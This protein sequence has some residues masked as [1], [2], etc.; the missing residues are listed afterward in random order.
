MWIEPKVTIQMVSEFIERLPLKHKEKIWSR[1]CVHNYIPKDKYLNAL[2]SFLALCIK[3]KDRAATAPSKPEV[4]ARL[5]PFVDQMTLR[6]LQNKGMTLEQFNHHLH[7]WVLE[8]VAGLVMATEAQLEWQQEIEELREQVLVLEQEK[9]HMRRASEIELAQVLSQ[10]KH[11]D[12]D[13]EEEDYDDDEQQIHFL[14]KRVHECEESIF[15]L[16]STVSLLEDSV[17][18]CEIKHPHSHM[19]YRQQQLRDKTRDSEDD[20]DKDGELIAPQLISS[21]DEVKTVPEIE[22]KKHNLNE[23]DNGFGHSSREFEEERLA[24]YR[25]DNGVTKNEHYIGW[26]NKADKYL[27]QLEEAIRENTGSR[28]ALKEW[29]QQAQN[30]QITVERNK[31]ELNINRE[32]KKT[33]ESLQ[34]DIEHFKV[35]HIQQEKI[36]RQSVAKLHDSLFVKLLDAEADHEDIVAFYQREVEVLKQN[37]SNVEDNKM[38]NIVHSHNTIHSMRI[39]I[40]LLQQDIVSLRAQL[41]NKKGFFNGWI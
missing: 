38:Q 2:H 19:K 31:E 16:Q 32:Y 41:K 25:N 18:E 14:R 40:K 10:F 34:K 17:A 30:L 35:Q 1:H 11:N 24:F 5:Q 33:V 13:D 9:L 21:D 12:E 37:L 36:R 4:E 39:D 7:T 23:S 15:C 6:T 3:I 22:E 28:D 29:K 26:K 27:A 8:P 20:D